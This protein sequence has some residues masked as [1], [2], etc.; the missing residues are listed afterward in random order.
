MEVPQNGWFIV[1]ILIKLDD[2]GVSLFQ[3]TSILLRMIIHALA[4]TGPKPLAHRAISRCNVLVSRS[5]SCSRM[6][7]KSRRCRDSWLRRKGVGENHGFWGISWDFNGF[8][9]NL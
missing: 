2:L 5:F 1:E 6:K 8:D 9:G 7:R 3:E 4:V